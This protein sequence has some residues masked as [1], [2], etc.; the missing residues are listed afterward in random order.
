MKE[1]EKHVRREGNTAYCGANIF[2]EWVF[3]DAEHGIRTE[4]GGSR[5]QM[6][7][8]CKAIVLKAER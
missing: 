8:D 4:K 6:C 1:W 3:V 5:L 2:T 7:P